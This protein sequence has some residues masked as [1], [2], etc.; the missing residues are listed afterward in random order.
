MVL[1]GIWFF[2][3][4]LLW[5]V[6]FMT[7]GFDFGVGALLPFLGKTDEDKR[8]MALKLSRSD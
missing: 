1:Q 4:G 2:L 5:A 8:V 3:W 7:D 6:F